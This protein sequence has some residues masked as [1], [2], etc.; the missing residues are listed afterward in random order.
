MNT[1]SAA[2]HII[3]F[4]LCNACAVASAQTVAQPGG[5]TPLPPQSATDAVIESTR[6]GARDTAEWLARGVDSWFGD[7]PFEGGGSV[8]DGRLSVSLL[9]REGESLDAD[10]RFNARFRLPNAERFGY[11]FIGRD[12]SR[13]LV[14]DRPGALTA[15][16][17]Q[18]EA[19]SAERSFFAGL[20]RNVNDAV[21]LRIGFRGGLNLYAQA[22]YRQAWVPQAHQR[23]EFRQT[24]F[25]ASDE[26]LGTTT[27]LS[28]EHLFSPEL[29]ARWVGAAT[30][31]QEQRRVEWQSTPGLYR[32]LGRDRQVAL[33]M[34]FSGRE[35]DGV[36]D[37]GVQVRWEQPVFDNRL[38]GEAVLGHFWPR[39][40]SLSVR[41]EAWAFGL[42]LKLRF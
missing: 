32:A 3:L 7:R 37:Y 41:S 40:N 23:F 24:L 9:K 26:K 4:A 6:Q 18:L 36:T 17:R 28:F 21:D 5:Q 30:L 16:D 29:A 2:R 31:T 22:R 19:S 8:R 34:P 25:W 42:G 33:E 39:P 10:L 15:R 38:V 35:G 1:F 11:L 20:G 12:N 27:A 14:T 13:D